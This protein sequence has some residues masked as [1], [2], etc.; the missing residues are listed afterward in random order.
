M[1]ENG[2]VKMTTMEWILTI[3]IIVLTL[4]A[5]I[6]LYI[7]LR[8]RR[9]ADYGQ[10]V[11]RRT[12]YVYYPNLQAPWFQEGQVS[13]GFGAAHFPTCPS[14]NGAN[15]YGGCP[16]QPGPG[17]YGY[18]SN[19]VYA[20][21]NGYGV[22]SAPIIGR[23]RTYVPTG[24]N[25]GHFSSP[26]DYAERTY[27]GQHEG[28]RRRGAGKNVSGTMRRAGGTS[29]EQYRG[30]VNRHASGSSRWRVDFV[31]MSSGR[32]VTRDFSGGLLV[33]RQMPDE[34]ESGKLYLSMDATVS[35][36]QFRLF[37]TDAGM[38]IENL[39]RVNI[40]R[41]NGY[42][43]WQPMRLEEGDVL[44]LGRKRYMVREICPAG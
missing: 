31:D 25:G 9:K 38:M 12:E 8:D 24:V 44:D 43:V 1:K 22:Y 32:H 3:E 42:P 28:G 17:Y 16:A 14:E 2:E 39:S 27:G 10:G 34:Q 41:K 26:S 18:A 13:S 40:T 20:R 33:G 35:R 15:A 6:L 7:L 4:L 21:G 30:P 36:S 29:G 5:C 11:D 19:G 37:V 23:E